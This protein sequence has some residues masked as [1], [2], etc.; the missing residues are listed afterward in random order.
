MLLDQFRSMHSII[1][2]VIKCIKS[3]E[4][5]ECGKSEP[6]LHSHLINTVFLVN[7]DFLAL[8]GQSVNATNSTAYFLGRCRL[9]LL[10]AP[11]PRL[12]A[13]LGDL[14]K[15]LCASTLRESLD[16]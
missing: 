16:S 15:S 11:L 6:Y 4:P 3:V 14:R 7:S 1:S 10:H 13:P 12:L 8:T 5:A 2:H 9:P